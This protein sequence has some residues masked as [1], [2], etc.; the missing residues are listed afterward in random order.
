MKIH[1]VL[2]A[3]C[4]PSL[5]TTL[6]W[7]VNSMSSNSLHSQAIQG[8]T[9]WLNKGAVLCLDTPKNGCNLPS[10]VDWHQALLQSE[11]RT[12]CCWNLK[13]AK[14]HRCLLMWSAFMNRFYWFG[15]FSV[16]ISILNI[17]AAI[18]FKFRMC[19]TLFCRVLKVYYSQAVK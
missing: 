11:A 5:K 13:W 2:H 12:E 6:L 3:P 1:S 18:F 19:E 10:Q 7:P 15:C 14:A 16:S 4:Q 17:L 8:R 9:V